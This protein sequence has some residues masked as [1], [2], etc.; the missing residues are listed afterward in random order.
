MGG[1]IFEFSFTCGMLLI[2]DKNVRTA[3]GQPSFQRF[4]KVF[5]SVP[6]R[7]ELLSISDDEE[8][9]QMWKTL[10][11]MRSDNNWESLAIYIVAKLNKFINDQY[12]SA[13]I[14]SA[15]GINIREAMD[16]NKVILVNLEK[17][18]LGADNAEYFGSLILSAITRAALSRSDISPQDRKPFYLFADEFQNFTSGDIGQALSEV[19]KYGLT[20]ILA[21]QTLGQL[22][23]YVA[24]SLLGNVGNQIFFRP[25]VTDSQ[26]LRP[27][28][29]RDFSESD[30]LNLPNF[31]AI[32]RLLHRDV[33]MQPFVMKTVC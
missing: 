21:N 5:L 24:D 14:N 3:A 13:I 9:K 32:A 23:Q 2:M 7:D 31:H 27:Y 12:F 20:M 4:C 6:Y 8:L 25:G 18:I 10:L 11:D 28:L 29:L 17:G 1:P 19:R 26:L 15:W 22:S 16:E 33:P 30:V